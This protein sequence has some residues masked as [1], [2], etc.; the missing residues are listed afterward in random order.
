MDF[1]K[2]VF[3]KWKK[4]KRKKRKERKK[5]VNTS[6]NIKIK[7]KKR[8]GKAKV[9]FLKKEKREGRKGKKEK[10]KQDNTQTT[11]FL[12]FPP[13]PR[14]AEKKICQKINKQH[15]KQPSFGAK[16]NRH[17]TRRKELKRTINH[18]T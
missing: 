12:C 10:R 18:L 15:P 5:C 1:K 17:Q 14:K 16:N 7:K 11:P 9:D 6:F 4:K 2:S 3:F 13:L 8:K